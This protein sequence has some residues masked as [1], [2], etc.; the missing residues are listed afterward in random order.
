MSAHD[1]QRE[2]DVTSK[3]DVSGVGLSFC[4]VLLWT[5]FLAFF[6]FFFLHKNSVIPFKSNSINIG[7]E[8]VKNKLLHYICL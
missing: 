4:Y 5:S 2:I 7:L 8:Y 6:F 3:S 1:V